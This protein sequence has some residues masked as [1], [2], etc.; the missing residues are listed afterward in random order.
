MQMLLFYLAQ[1]QRR[2]HFHRPPDPP[3]T[4]MNFSVNSSLAA[5]GRR[6][7]RDHSA[8]ARASRDA[9]RPA[10]PGI[11]ESFASDWETGIPTPAARPGIPARPASL[12]PSSRR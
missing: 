4:R 1:R 9:T 8:P 5:R 7:Q 3:H 10:S 2:E 11:R 12:P 6:R